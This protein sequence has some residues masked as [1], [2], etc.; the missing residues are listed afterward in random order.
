MNTGSGTVVLNFIFA[1]FIVFG[2][3]MLRYR[4]KK[5]QEL[6][7]LGRPLLAHSAAPGAHR[8]DSATREAAKGY[9]LCKVC[10]FENFKASLFCMICGEKI[11]IDEPEDEDSTAGVEVH[12]KPGTNSTVT[13]QLTQRQIRAR[14]RKEWSRKLDIEGKMFWYR[15]QLGR[16]ISSLTPGLV[17]RFVSTSPFSV[18]DDKSR[19]QDQQQEL[20]QSSEEEKEEQAILIP[21]ELLETPEAQASSINGSEPEA[22][23]STRASEPTSENANADKTKSAM[24]TTRLSFLSDIVAMNVVEASQADA[25]VLAT[26]AVDGLDAIERRKEVVV[27][28][29]QDFPTKYAH[30][31]VSTA[32]LLVPAEVEFLKV[33]VHRSFVLEE[34]MDHLSCIQERFIRSVMRIN[35]IDE[36]GVDAGGLHR[37][38]FMLLNDLLMEAS[39]GLFVCTS[40]SDQVY[41]LNPNSRQDNGED[42]LVYYYATGRLVGRALLEGVVLNF[43]L[44]VPLLKIILGIP[45]TMDDVEYFDPEAYKSMQWITQNDNI[46]ALALD[47][48]VTQHHRDEETGELVVEIIDLIPNGRNIPVTDANKLQY[49]ERKFHFMLFESVSSQLHMFLKGLYEVVPQHLLMLFD[50]EELD[51]LLCGSQEIDVNDWIKWSVH[52]AYLALT[53]ALKNFWDV[54]REMPNEYKRRLLQFTTGCSRV[55]LIGFR[56]LTSYD[57]K[58]CHFTIKALSSSMPQ[59]IRSHACF[60]RI[61]LPVGLSKR[62][63]HDMLYAI[64]DTEMYGFTT[65]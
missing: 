56:G 9:N 20:A 61:D 46:E 11:A 45:V 2:F 55:P 26:G 4:I 43:H 29:A 10:A 13:A 31:V 32:S 12:V 65:T 25:S 60:N 59:I 35:F 14:K 57:G 6:S 42:H 34:S 8:L 53:P 63:L 21:D 18:E 41:A 38:W 37:E 5:L 27:H 22:S 15:E 36:S 17:V 3:F 16:A 30:F 54:V 39:T 33:S 28:A 44:A 50:A 47:F 52:S 58:V 64:L 62:E 23:P 7:E 19:A 49:L 51:Y 40:K 48:S 1:F 24:R